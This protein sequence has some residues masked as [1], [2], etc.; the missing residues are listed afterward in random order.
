MQSAFD[1]VRKLGLQLEGS[2][3]ATSYGSP[4]LKVRG[5]TFVA[6]P[7]NKSAEPDSIVV[8]VSFTERDLRLRA[9]PRIYY[10]K[11]HYEG[12]QCVLAR[13]TLMTD[14]AL[15]ELLETAWQFVRTTKRKTRR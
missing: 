2:E 3:E 13:V 9:E 1:R 11:P 10:L 4:A 5:Q 8:R 14:D 12:S 6:I 7:T 15:A